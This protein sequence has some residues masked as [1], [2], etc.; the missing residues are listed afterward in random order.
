MEKM[1]NPNMI[2]K[3]IKHDVYNMMYFY[4][5]FVGRSEDAKLIEKM[6]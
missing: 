6:I 1:F 4:L 3:K 5:V 2:S